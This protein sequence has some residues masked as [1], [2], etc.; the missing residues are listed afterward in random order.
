MPVGIKYPIKVSLDRLFLDP[1]NPR[2]ANEHR[3]GYANP[4]TF[5]EEGVQA[6]LEQQIRK[7]YRV[8]ALINAILGM[9]WTPVYAMLV[10]TPP[11]TPG[12]YFVGAADTR[13]LA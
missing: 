4:G 5:F 10:W 8:G 6:E 2:L 11:P 12:L 1:N 3:P 13:P 7:R 9:G